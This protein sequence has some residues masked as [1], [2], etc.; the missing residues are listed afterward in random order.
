MIIGQQAGHSLEFPKIQ[1]ENCLHDRESPGSK[2]LNRVN[3][4]ILP[5]SAFGCPTH[6]LHGFSLLEAHLPGTGKDGGERCATVKPT[7]GWKVRK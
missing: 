2:E 1:S 5:T 6:D 3:L 4:I 7:D